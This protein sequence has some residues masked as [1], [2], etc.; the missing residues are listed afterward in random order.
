MKVGD[1]ITTYGDIP[2]IPVRPVVGDSHPLGA[3]PA[4][5]EVFNIEKYL[6]ETDRSGSVT[7]VQLIRGV[8]GIRF[9]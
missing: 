7:A 5:T 8:L 4:G 6:G 9:K 2:R 3:L 1:I